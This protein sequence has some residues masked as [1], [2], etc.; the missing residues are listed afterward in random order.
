MALPGITFRVETP[1]QVTLPRMDI[2]AFVGFAARGPL[3]TPVPIEDLAQYRDLFGG[4]L[5]LAWDADLGGWQTACLGYA[6]ADFFAQGGR[7]CWVVRVAGEAATSNSFPVAG[8]LGATPGG[9]APATAQARCAGSWSDGLEVGAS[10]MSQALAFEP[11]SAV[12]GSHLDGVFSTGSR[13]G[14]HPGDLLKL[15]FQGG[16]SAYLLAEQVSAAGAWQEVEGEARWFRPLSPEDTPLSGP[17]VLAGPAPLTSA[18]LR[19]PDG[20]ALEVSGG[21]A[22]EPG[23]WLTLE[24][25]TGRVWLLAEQS[26]DD[27][28]Q[29]RGAWQEVGDGSPVSLERATRVTMALE[30]R[31]DQQSQG[32]LLDLAFGEAHPRFWGHLP[33]DESY[34]ALQSGRPRPPQGHPGA[35]LREQ[36]A[37]P[38]RYPL[39]GESEPARFYIPLG[40]ELAPFAW[41][42]GLPLAGSPLERDGL[43]PPEALS[44]PEFVQELFLDPA[45]RW[46]GEGAVMAEAADLLYGQGQALRGMHS[47]LPLDEVSMLALPD[48]AHLGW[49]KEPFLPAPP[50]VAPPE[51]EPPEPCPG[52]EVFTGKAPKTP[53]EAPEEEPEAGL[54]LSGPD[55]RW[56]LRTN[57]AF[58]QDGAQGLLEVQR[59]A[60]EFAAARGDLIAVLALPPGTRTREGLVHRQALGEQL[61]G[62][63][64]ASYAALAHPWLIERDPAGVL[65]RC[66]PEGVLCGMMA[67]RSRTRGAWV[68]PANQIATSALALVPE[69]D[70]GEFAEL[71]GA[72]FNI[73]KPEVRGF[74]LWGSSTLSEDPD[75]SALN[76]RRLMSLLRR[77]ALREGQ[78]YVFEPHSPAFQRQ[79]AASMENL[80]AGLFARGAFA[81]R[82]ESEAFQVVADSTVNT[83]ASTEQ[84][85]FIVELR[86]APSL[87]LTFLTVRLIETGAGTFIVQEG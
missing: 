1:E 33:T 74:A 59:K 28:I 4:P 63:S 16:L 34:F 15:E 66:S 14:L 61:A 75:I 9:L 21:L 71:H 60:A 36:A 84:G 72:G 3:H 40:L 73:F 58:E 46:T 70:R 56:A 37:A 80:L 65:R 31:R 11:L 44:W 23:D 22:P 39:A 19:S 78:N 52:H 76:V 83:P 62:R 20:Q 67:H 13:D 53:D 35:E 18:E 5:P 7:R 85:R 55:E 10:L 6:V 32:L 45:L 81:G 79:V 47:L 30:G 24:A 69:I 38:P 17:L 68:S 29:V 48:A 82:D 50:P 51:D 43:A 26:L 87:P 54:A 49:E 8:L 64:T 77:V 42:G 86:V 57:A 12:P 25:P 2:A 27:R 41:R